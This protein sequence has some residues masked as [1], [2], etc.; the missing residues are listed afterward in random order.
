MCLF[1][2]F[3]LHLIYLYHVDI[4]HSVAIYFYL[5]SLLRSQHSHIFTWPFVCIPVVLFFY[6][7]TRNKVED[8]LK[9]LSML[10]GIKQGL[11]KIGGA[12]NVI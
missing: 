12:M 10:K 7:L 5:L 3:P 9:M 6:I 1:V 11:L 4:P 8:A 2:Y